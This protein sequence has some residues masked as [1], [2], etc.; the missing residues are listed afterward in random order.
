MSSWVCERHGIFSRADHLGTSLQGNC[1]VE[2]SDSLS[3]EGETED[4]S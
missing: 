4:L 2:F 1:Q 3:S